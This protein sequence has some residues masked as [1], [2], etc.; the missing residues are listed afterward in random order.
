MAYLQEIVIFLV[1]NERTQGLG[2]DSSG[3]GDVAVVDNK[4]LHERCPRSVGVATCLIRL[5]GTKYLMRGLVL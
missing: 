1:V 2:D 4:D 5:M 3:F